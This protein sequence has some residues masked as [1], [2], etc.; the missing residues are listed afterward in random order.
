ML[1]GVKKILYFSDNT[2]GNIYL[3]SKHY[4][5][6]IGYCMIMK[7]FLRFAS[8]YLFLFLLF[9]FGISIKGVCIAR[10]I[11]RGYKFCVTEEVIKW[12]FEAEIQ[13]KGFSFPI[14]YFV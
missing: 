4:L 5:S 11:F 6:L 7:K 8:V 2:Y 13:K 3:M 14:F 9:F 12:I 1:F 10:V